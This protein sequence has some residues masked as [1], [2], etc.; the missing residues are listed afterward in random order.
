MRVSS[1][2]GT[3][4][5]TALISDSVLTPASALAQDAAPRAITLDEA[6]RLAQQNSPTT[7]QARNALRVGRMTVANSLAQFLPNLGLQSNA[8]NTNRGQ[9]IQGKFTPYT[10]DP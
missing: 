6:V 4:A 2:C 7:V 10:G 3:L 1:F 9:F 5:L 8:S